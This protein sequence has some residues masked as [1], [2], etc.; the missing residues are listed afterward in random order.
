MTTALATL[1][2]VDNMRRPL[3]NVT[4]QLAFIDNSIRPMALSL[5]KI[6]NQIDKMDYTVNKNVNIHHNYIMTEQNISSVTN[7]IHQANHAQEQLNESMEQAKGK[8]SG[9]L[10]KV[11]NIARVFK[12]FATDE[13]KAV[14][15]VSDQMVSTQVK[16]GL[17][18]DEGQSVEQLQ[19]N[20][21]AAAQRAR[22]DFTAMADY[23]HE[24]GVQAGDSFSNTD[25]IVSFTETLQ[26]AFKA[27]GA[28]IDEQTAGMNQLLQGMA[29]GQLQSQDFQMIIEDAPVLADAMASF[30]GKSKDELMKL[31]SEGQLTAQMLKGALFSATDDINQKLNAVPLTFG[32][33]FQQFKNTAFQAFQPLFQ[34]LNDWLNSTSGSQM[35][36]MMTNALFFAAQVADG[37]LAALISI[38][39][40]IQTHWSIIEPILVSIGSAL[41]LWSTQFIPGLITK[42]WLMIQPILLQASAWLLA[43]LPILLIGAAIGFLIYAMVRW[44]DVVTQVVGVIGGLFGMLFAFFYNRF[45][46]FANFILSI[47][48]FFINV[49]KDPIYAVKKLFYDFVISSLKFLHNLAKGIENIINNIPGLKVNMTDGMSNLLNRLEEARD[50]LKSEEDVVHLNRF[51]QKDYGEAFKAGQDIGETV[52]R[53]ATDGVQDAFDAIGNLFKQ[54]GLNQTDAG[55]LPTMDA[56]QIDTINQIDK[57]GEVEQIGNTVDISNEDLKMMRELAE[58]RAIQNYVSLTPTVQVSTGPIHQDVDIDTVVSRIETALTEEIASSAKGVYGVG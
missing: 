20:I 39:E 45:A 52:G 35:I 5:N 16:L 57:V 27:S 28:S 40:T 11:K 24:L 1:D 44:G 36:Q 58:M 42:L 22:T 6:N 31:S 49:W 25:E 26:K 2:M 50:N 3:N 33:V 37:L 4:N 12:E 56:S 17:V 18:V 8:S 19:N 47:A 51:E 21:Y 43:N 46:T 29:A 32:E 55:F 34:R 13:F 41:A 38:F 23:I 9:F 7:R 10:A 15:Q 30:T 53:F 54:P 48:E 14:I